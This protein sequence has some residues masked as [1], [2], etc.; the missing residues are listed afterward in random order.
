MGAIAEAAGFLV[1]AVG[2]TLG[3]KWALTGSV[4]DPKPSQ[5]PYPGYAQGA[6]PPFVDPMG[7][8]IV[9]GLFGSTQFSES[10]FVV[11][12]IVGFI[13]AVRYLKH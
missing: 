11:L 7:K 3:V 12:L 1:K 8:G 2:G 10:F 13:V 9:G 5:D 6:P 4:S